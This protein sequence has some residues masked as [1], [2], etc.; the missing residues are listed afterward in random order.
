MAGK[1]LNIKPLS[2]RV[3]VKRLEEE[4]QKTAGGIIVPDTAV[5]KIQ[6]GKETDETVI[7]TF[8]GQVG[9]ELHYGDTVLI[10][11]SREEI[12]LLVPPEHSYFHILR[13]KL[14]WGG[15][16]VSSGSFRANR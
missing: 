10:R 4:M 6:L 9:L 5:I 8:D 11:D 2:N 15:A 3:L 16:T 7:V 1:K 12:S 13:T 14:M